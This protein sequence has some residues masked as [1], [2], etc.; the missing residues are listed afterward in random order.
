MQENDRSL[1]KIDALSVGLF[2]LAVGALTLGLAQLDFIPPED[3]VAVSVI[4]L[5]FGGLV[6]IVA[7]LIDIGHEDQLGGTALTMYGFFWTTLFTIKLLEQTVSFH[8]DELLFFPLF[9]VFAV[10]SAVMIYLTAHRSIVLMVLHIIITITF[11]TAIFL[12]F[13][14]NVENTLG[15]LHVLIGTIAFYH[16]LATLVNRFH[17][18]GTLPLGEPLLK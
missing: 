3:K 10:F 18:G 7:G 6:Q 15:I 4:C 5:V 8:W 12:A 2:G 17:C 14:Y 13:N 9:T 1:L 11:T 16:A